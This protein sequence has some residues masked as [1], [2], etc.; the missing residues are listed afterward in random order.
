MWDPVDLRGPLWW[1]TTSEPSAVMFLRTLALL[2]L[3]Q[4]LNDPIPEIQ[5]PQQKCSCQGETQPKMKIIK[6]EVWLIL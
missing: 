2:C 5:V 3:A 1:Q 6:G 4:P